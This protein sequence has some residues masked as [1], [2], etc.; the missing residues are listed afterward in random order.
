MMP[1]VPISCGIQKHVVSTRHG[2]SSVSQGFRR[3]SIMTKVHVQRPDAWQARSCGSD[4][5]PSA[6]LDDADSV[7]GLRTMP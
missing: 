7:G 3:N 1:E 4:R 2:F 5:G 6:S